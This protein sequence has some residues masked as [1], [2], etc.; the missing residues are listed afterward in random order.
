MLG[1][2]LLVKN[3]KLLGKRLLYDKLKG[4]PEN[5]EI[6]DGKLIIMKI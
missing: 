6:V 5:Q 2:M 4:S 1:I 3:Y